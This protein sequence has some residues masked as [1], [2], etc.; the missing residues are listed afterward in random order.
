MKLFDR[1]RGGIIARLRKT[2]R[3]GAA[4][5]PV[6]AARI[7]SDGRVVQTLNLDPETILEKSNPLWK[8][9]RKRLWKH[10]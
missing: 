5:K 1:L 7:R 9:L 8:R 10:P 2:G 3:S 6:L 4:L